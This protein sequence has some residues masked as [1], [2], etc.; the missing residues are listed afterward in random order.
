MAGQINRGSFLGDYAYNLASN[1][2]LTNY[3]EVGTWNGE[4]S[5]ECLMD[6]LLGRPDN[7]CLYSLEANI[8]FYN[9]AKR[10]WDSK[11]VSPEVLEKKLKLI[12]GRLT[13]IEDVL[14]VEEV[15][16]HAI[17]GQHPWL[18]W[19]SRNIKEYGQCEMVLDQLPKEVDVLFL[20][21]GQFSTREEFRKL[22]HRTKVILLDDPA[23]YKTE[24]IRKEIVGDRDSWEILFD[25]PT[26]RMS[27]TFGACKREYI[28][29]LK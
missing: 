11:G 1:T 27:G 3:V 24:S 6:G 12:Y 21:G 20:D 18:E 26:D 29:L 14:S 22:K 7:S 13:E 16:D 15:R 10:Y 19:R 4:G 25:K 5:T 9:Q 8:E 2:N 17:F 23:T 28:S